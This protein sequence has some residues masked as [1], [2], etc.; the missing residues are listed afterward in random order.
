MFPQTHIHTLN[1]HT[2]LHAVP[3]LCATF[4]YV[5]H[6]PNSQTYIHACQVFQV[7]MLYIYIHA[8]TAPQD[9][10]VSAATQYPY[11]RQT[12]NFRRVSVSSR[13]FSSGEGCHSEIAGGGTGQGAAPPRGAS[14]A[15]PCARRRLCNVCLVISYYPG[16]LPRMMQLPRRSPSPLR[17]EP[18]RTST[19]VQRMS[20]DLLLPRAPAS[21]DA[22]T[23]TQSQ[24]P[25]RRSHASCTHV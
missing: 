15:S 25:A 19:P 7:S 11:V 10:D 18:L 16:P 1:I 5:L 24:P 20:G 2:Y 14:E 3:A 23:P 17:S 13:T 4:S 9:P 12:S 21:N 6:T 22:T 8:S